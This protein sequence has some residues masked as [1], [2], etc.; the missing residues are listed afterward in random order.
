MLF[1]PTT[2]IP[3]IPPNCV[4]QTQFRSII[5]IGTYILLQIF[6]LRIGTAKVR[7]AAKSTKEKEAVKGS[8]KGRNKDKNLKRTARA[9][10]S[11]QKTFLKNSQTT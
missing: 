11:H 7:K 3:E 10:L 4:Y 5:M 2:N 6:V 1:R 8:Y 9:H